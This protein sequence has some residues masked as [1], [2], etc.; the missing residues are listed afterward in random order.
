MAATDFANSYSRRLFIQD[1]LTLLWFLIDTGS[2]VSC[3][4]ATADEMKREPIRLLYAANGTPIKVF[5]EKL[6]EL[7]L[8]LRRAITFFFF[9]ILQPFYYIEVILTVIV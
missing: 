6:V 2:D 4:P 5:G 7:K 8:G 3:I 1:L 9:F